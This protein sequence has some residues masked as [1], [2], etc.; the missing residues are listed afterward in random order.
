MIEV[1]ARAS[2][3]RWKSLDTN[4]KAI[5]QDS[6]SLGLYMSAIKILEV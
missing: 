3:S 6:N 5:W 2:T 1:E 4:R